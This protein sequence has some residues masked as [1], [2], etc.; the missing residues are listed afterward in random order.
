MSNETK[1][2]GY[3]KR[4]VELG[5]AGKHHQA[6]TELSATVQ[7]EPDFVEAYVSLGVALH[8]TGQ[9]ERALEMYDTAL[10]L[11]P[12]HAEAHYFRANIYYARGQSPQ[13]IAGYTTAM[14][15][16]PALINAHKNPLPGNRLTDYVGPPDPLS[17][18]AMYWITK[19]ASRILRCDKALRTDP[20]NIEA[21][22]ERG[23][24][25][26][27]LGNY[28]YAVENFTSLLKISSNDVQVL[29]YRGLAYEQLEQFEQALADY[30]RAIELKPDF[31]DA[32]INRGV[33]YGKMGN[34]QHSLTDL[35]QGVSLNPNDPN[36]Y[37]NRGIARHQLGD[38]E[39]TIADFSQVLEFNPND[40]GAHWWRDQAREKATHSASAR[41]STTSDSTMSISDDFL[42]K[43]TNHH[44]LVSA[45]ATI[46]EAFA[47]FQAAGG[48]S[49][50][51]FVID[52]GE[53]G[54]IQ[55]LEEESET[56]L[57]RRFLTIF[58]RVFRGKTV[59][60]APELDSEAALPQNLYTPGANRYGLLW[61]VDLAEQMGLRGSGPP[62]WKGALS[63]DER[64][65]FWLKSNKLVASI[66]PS[67]MLETVEKNSLSDQKV[68]SLSE[69]S[70]GRA[71]VVLEDGQ[72]VGLVNN[73]Y[74]KY[75]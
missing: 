74:N 66:E 51:V 71:L 46:G 16:E 39:G 31:A 57:F 17:P 42:T 1:S 70:P 35:D 55:N 27:E 38:F 50:W 45:Q 18:V 75:F 26:Y 12:K 43:R 48:E 21:Y 40:Q 73:R 32:Y 8:R 47:A 67:D 23:S 28:E 72:Y 29:H 20:Q 4:G 7:A 3:F 11:S 25:Y 2:Q 59:K 62:D 15:L 53:N 61:L 68:W 6:I 19:P 33:T 58:Q 52:Y 49:W 22:R 37:Y 56:R 34:Q 54:R 44:L 60:K 36:G 13:A 5:L 69:R 10:K 30:S 14:G 41:L 65:R 9:D 63:Y 64:V 24:A